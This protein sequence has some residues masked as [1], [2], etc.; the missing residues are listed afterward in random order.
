MGGSDLASGYLSLIK[1]CKCASIHMALLQV[2]MGIWRPHYI[3]QNNSYHSLIVLQ[4]MHTYSIFLMLPHV[5]VHTM[6]YVPIYVTLPIF[7]IIYTI[8]TMPTSL[9]LQHPLDH[10]H[11]ERYSGALGSPPHHYL[12]KG[13][14]M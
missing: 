14:Q 4:C 5:Y 2:Y 11:L 8:P 10:H 1:M 7:L 13:S 3:K 6:M 9:I 12:S